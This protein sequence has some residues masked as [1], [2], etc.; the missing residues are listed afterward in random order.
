M[1]LV[2]TKE[3]TKG[4][5]TCTVAF[6]VS[7]MSQ[8]TLEDQGIFKRSGGQQTQFEH[9]LHAFSV[10]T[11]RNTQPRATNGLAQASNKILPLPSW[12]PD[13]VPHCSSNLMDR[14]VP[15]TSKGAFLLRN[16]RSPYAVYFCPVT[17]CG[18]SW[19]S[20]WTDPERCIP[21]AGAA[22]PA[23]WL[24]KECRQEHAG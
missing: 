10:A 13:R 22:E 11:I 12:P 21:A 1:S 14:W 2:V 7:N 5:V 17:G 18:Q 9:M 15:V 16:Q 3:P 4:R 8:K 23:T 19:R 24:E 6:V 20:V